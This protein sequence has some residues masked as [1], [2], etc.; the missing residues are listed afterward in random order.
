MNERQMTA[1]EYCQ[2]F[3][4]WLPLAEK[5]IVGFNQGN[6]RLAVEKSC[7]LDRMIYGGEQPSQ[8]PCPVHEGKWRGIGFM[9]PV[10]LTVASPE[11]PRIMTQIEVIEAGCRCYKHTCGCTTGWQPD[12]HCGCL[13]PSL[14][15]PKPPQEKQ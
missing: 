14:A 8:T 11:G 6:V 10:S 12:E 13:S 2:R 3:Y 5:H 9:G 1:R 15:D 4:A 7:L